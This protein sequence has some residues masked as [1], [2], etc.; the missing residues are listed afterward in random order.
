M[1]QLVMWTGHPG[2]GWS[3]GHEDE[4]EAGAVE[5]EGAVEEPSPNRGDDYR[6]HDMVRKDV[7]WDGWGTILE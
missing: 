3:P 7:E 6:N 1:Y 4:E 5:E 2:Q